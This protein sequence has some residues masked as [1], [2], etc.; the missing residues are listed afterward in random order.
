MKENEKKEETEVSE[1][2]EEV[3]EEELEEAEKETVVEET[4]ETEEEISEE[5]KE[6]IEKR[7]VKKRG[8][9]KVPEYILEKEIITSDEEKYV[10]E[11]IMTVRVYPKLLSAPKWKRAKRAAKLL[12]E[13][14]DKYVKYAPHPDTKEKVRLD[15][16]YIWI[17]PKVNE[18]IWSRGAKNPPRKLRVRVVI[19]FLEPEKKEG[20]VEAELRVLPLASR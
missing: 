14:V 4:V 6:E 8:P 17:H 19:K 9:K 15:R 1:E 12:R 20:K 18:L 16:K 13:M 7:R 3:A 5:L 10:V 11:R 2:N